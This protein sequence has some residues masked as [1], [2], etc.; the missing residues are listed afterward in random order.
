MKGLRKT[1]MKA[2]DEVWVATAL[3]HREHP[4]R[5]TFTPREILR[6]AAEEASPDKVRPAVYQH[7]VQHCVANKPP[8]PGRYRMLYAIGKT[9]RLFR[10]G[11]PYH[12]DRRGAKIVPEIEDLPR[13]YRY[14]LDWYRSE[15]APETMEHGTADPILQLRGV[16]KHIWAGEDPDDY[17]L[18]LRERWV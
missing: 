15:Y 10:L 9:R 11:D 18:R 13:E 6:R 7:A 16:G 17:V 8:D 12:P 3:L 2:A 4:E 5:T 14:L 1:S